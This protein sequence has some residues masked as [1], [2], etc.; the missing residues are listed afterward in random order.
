M[1]GAP[2]TMAAAHVGAPG[3]LRAPCMQ[4]SPVVLN[5]QSSPLSEDEDE[6]GGARECHG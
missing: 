5:W 3:P 6:V 1:H 2:P 4:G